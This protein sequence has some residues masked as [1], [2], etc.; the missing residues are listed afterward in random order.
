MNICKH[1]VQ[2][3]QLSHVFIESVITEH[4]P[5]NHH[6]EVAWALWMARSLGI[7]I[8]D[9]CVEPILDAMNPI[10]VL[11][12]I[13][14]GQNGQLETRPDLS[15]WGGS[16]PDDALYGPS[17]MLIYEGVMQRWLIGRPASLVAADPYFSALQADDVH[18]YDIEA[19]NRPLSLPGIGAKLTAAVVGRRRGLSYF[20]ATSVL[21]NE[22][23]CWWR[24]STILSV[25]GMVIGGKP[26]SDTPGRRRSPT[27]K[28]WISDDA[29]RRQSDVGYV[30]VLGSRCR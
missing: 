2:H 16:L 24:R 19:R 11:L 10:C 25:L 3:F 20:Q 22:R 14:L 30:A 7:K 28:T 27:M 26:H 4:A 5:L 9:R 18:F 6:Y 23:A 17:W 8:S 13:H 21:S 12:C 29:E 1:R 15:A